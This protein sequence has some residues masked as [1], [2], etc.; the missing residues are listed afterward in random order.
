[1]TVERLVVPFAQTRA[2]WLAKQERFC[3]L[4]TENASAFLAKRYHEFV[5]DYEYSRA[6]FS[7]LQGRFLPK[8]VK[9]RALFSWQTG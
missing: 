5:K 4:D 2:A 9:E 6:K 8:N 1:V 3:R 7:G